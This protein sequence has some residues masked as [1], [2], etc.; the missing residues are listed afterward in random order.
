MYA[1]ILGNEGY[2]HR[3][4]AAPTATKGTESCL[5]VQPIFLHL[6]FIT[7]V[8]IAYIMRSGMSVAS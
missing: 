5:I 8:I 4:E 3:A 1:M 7:Q 2:L 6:I